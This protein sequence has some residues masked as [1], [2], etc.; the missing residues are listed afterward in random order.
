MMVTHSIFL[1]YVI[2]FCPYVGMFNKFIE[3]IGVAINVALSGILYYFVTNESISNANI[4]LYSL[5]GSACLLAIL[6]L[7]QL[8]VIMRKKSTQVNIDT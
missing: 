3:I 6:S 7:I 1:L 4:V 8:L 5:I 2:I